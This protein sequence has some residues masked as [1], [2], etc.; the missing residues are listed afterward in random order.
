MLLSS[1]L[2]T[3]CEDSSTILFDFTGDL[4]GYSDPK[5]RIILHKFSYNLFLKIWLLWPLFQN[6]L[7]GH[8]IAIIHLDTNWNTKSYH[9]IKVVKCLTNT[10]YKKRNIKKINTI[11]ILIMGLVLVFI[12]LINRW[13]VNHCLLHLITFSS[14][15]FYKTKQSN[16]WNLQNLFFSFFAI[17]I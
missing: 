11:I 3:S 13:Y 10:L 14:F 6:W 15:R 2:D 16:S 4:E 8:Q 9:S 5:Q 1:S 7:L 12:T 17:E